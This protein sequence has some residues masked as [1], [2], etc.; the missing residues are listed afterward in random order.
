MSFNLLL[1]DWKPFTLLEIKLI[2]MAISFN[3]VRT[4]AP[5]ENCPPG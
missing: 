1:V 3:D 5:E 2:L 4:I